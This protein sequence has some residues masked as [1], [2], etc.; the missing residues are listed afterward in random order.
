MHEAARSVSSLELESVNFF[1][2][3]LQ[4]KVLQLCNLAG[5]IKMIRVQAR[6]Q[7]GFGGFDR[8]PLLDQSW[9]TTSTIS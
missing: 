8:T 2:C 3:P 5:Y 7:G 9:H 4:A 1:L 6:S